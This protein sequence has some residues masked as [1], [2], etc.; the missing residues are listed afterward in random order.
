MPGGIASADAIGAAAVDSN[1]R[2]LTARFSVPEIPATSLLGLGPMTI[3]R[4]GTPKDFASNVINA[5]G[6]D[7]RVRQGLALE[8]SLGLLK[9]FRVPLSVYQ[10]SKRARIVSNILLSLAT[11]RP[12]GDTAS[13]DLAWGLR[14]PL[15]D[16]GDVFADSAYTR[17]FGDALVGCAPKSPPDFVPRNTGL[18]QAQVDSQFAAI[19]PLVDALNAAQIG[20]AEKAAERLGKEAARELWNAPNL[21]IAYAGNVRL[22]NS[23]LSDRQRV[24]DRVWLTGAFPLSALGRDAPVVKATQ[25]IFYADYTRRQA[26]DTLKEYSALAYG[27]RLAYGSPSANVFVELLGEHRSEV[28]AAA[29]ANSNGWSAGLEILV[30]DELWISTGFGKRADELLK[31]DKTVIVANIKWGMSKKSFLAR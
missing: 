24:A 12:T 6:A 16:R 9:Q 4:P 10:R 3:V 5:I 29:K 19:K 11:S 25:A 30:S 20:C 13:T 7:G 18:S 31:P 17:R 2:D 8:A 26:I 23:R 22:V 21:Y 14:A 27:A 15:I 1:Q 28:A